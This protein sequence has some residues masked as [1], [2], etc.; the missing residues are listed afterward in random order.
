MYVKYDKILFSEKNRK[1]TLSFLEKME[2]EP[3]PVQ[4]SIDKIVENTPKKS[5]RPTKDKIIIV[6][7]LER[8]KG[9]KRTILNREDT[10]KLF[11]YLAQ[12]NCIFNGHPNM[13]KTAFADAINA[14]T[15]FS[16]G[17]IEDLLLYENIKP[18]N[19]AEKIKT[20]DMI[21]YLIIKNL[22]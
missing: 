4:I 2:I 13:S 9:D 5:G 3:L 8:E 20:I 22:Q 18:K 17:Q 14:L 12:L 16:A 19:N 7:P 10:A 11:S 21:K 6:K 1:V 15:G